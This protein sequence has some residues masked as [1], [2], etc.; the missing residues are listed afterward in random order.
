ML[1]FLLG[2][3]L[4]ML[5]L[6][7]LST[8]QQEATCENT[9]EHVRSLSFFAV[10]GPL[11]GLEVFSTLERRHLES[12][13][14]VAQRYRRYLDGRKDFRQ[15]REILSRLLRLVD[16][17]VCLVGYFLSLF[18]GIR[19]EVGHGLVERVS[20][21]LDGVARDGNDLGSWVRIRVGRRGSHRFFGS[22]GEVVWQEGLWGSG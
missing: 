16:C 8:A 17:F 15:R 13:S 9:K 14:D 20:S 3:L 18:R 10:Q 1:L 5:D 11:D 22:G 21:G 2:F 7:L 12:G 4:V 19:R 6:F